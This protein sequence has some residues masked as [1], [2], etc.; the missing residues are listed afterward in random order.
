MDTVTFE[1]EHSEL[2]EKLIRLVNYT[3]SE[4][5]FKLDPIKKTLIDQYKIS[6]EISLSNLSQLLYGDSINSSMDS[7]SVIL[8]LMLAM[9]KGPSGFSPTSSDAVFTM[10][11]KEI[12][13]PEEEDINK[14]EQAN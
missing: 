8:P 12:E 10:P 9:M 6:T 1:K 7:S 13:A 2:K 14:E 3:N 5:Y 11:T 4:E